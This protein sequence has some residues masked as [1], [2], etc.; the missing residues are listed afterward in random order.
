MHE[1]YRE[2]KRLNCHP[3]RSRRISPA[4]AYEEDPLFLKQ[5][6]ARS[7]GFAQDDSSSFTE[8]WMLQ[9]LEQAE[10]GWFAARP[11]PMVGCVIVDHTTNTLVAQGYHAH[12]GD[13]HA[14]V[15]A[16]AQLSK[17]ERDGDSPDQRS[18]PLPNPL[19]QNT[20]IHEGG[21]RGKPVSPVERRASSAEASGRRGDLT[22]YV[23]LEPCSHYGK[24]PPCMDALI[25]S[26]I[27]HVVVA[28]QDP[29]P[30]VAGRGIQGLRDAG[31][32]VEVGVLEEGAQL[33]NTPFLFGVTNNRPHVTLKMAQ[34]LDG[35]IATRQGHS[36]WISGLDARKWVHQMRG[37]FQ[38]ILS[39]AE[40]VIKDNAQLTVRCDDWDYS[41]DGGHP[42]VRIILDRGFRIRKHVILSPSANGG[43]GV[44]ASPLVLTHDLTASPVWLCVDEHILAKHPQDAKLL[45]DR[46]VTLIPC[47]SQSIRLLD[48]S[49]TLQLL[50]QRGMRSLWV[51]A[52]GRLSST[53]LQ[54]GL[55]DD[56][57]T[58]I[59]PKI[60]GDAHAQTPAWP[61]TLHGSM[62]L[63][64]D[65]AQTLQLKS[66]RQL[67]N[68]ILAHLST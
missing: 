55:V 18:T 31:I 23:T 4:K 50:H 37:G 63:V 68:D 43:N 26:G 40:T 42:P 56:L 28:M 16:L 47:P 35:A 52:G 14:E 21:L 32:Q 30:Q 11:N 61:Q 33:L 62:P 58:I 6:R 17:R 24:T 49:K 57:Y 22:A 39:T 65:D 34:T 48:L 66:V 51:E 59:A 7:F 12:Y 15:N 3:E 45:N 1:A 25:A 53:L 46:G 8:H 20:S 27:K 44:E 54:K 10:R 64:M 5:E 38:G 60:L 19:P 36:Q 41:Q 13:A 9:A 2:W 67:G 29:N